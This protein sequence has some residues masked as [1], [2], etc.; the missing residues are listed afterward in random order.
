MEIWAAI[1]FIILSLLL[2]RRSSTRLLQICICVVYAVAIIYLAFISREP[3]P[4][5]HY[6][7]NLF[8]GARRGLEFGGGVLAGLL[9]GDVK[10][11]SAIGVRHY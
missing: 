5:H 2:L 11:T 9:H 7:V 3:M 8:G 10:I 4:I 1:G 6:S